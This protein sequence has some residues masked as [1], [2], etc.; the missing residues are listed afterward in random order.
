MKSCNLF[1]IINEILSQLEQK[2]LS[3]RTCE[4]Q[5]CMEANFF[6]I[7][8]PCCN[9]LIC[10]K[11]IISNTIM[12][13]KHQKCIIC[14]NTYICRNVQE[15][16]KTFRSIYLGFAEQAP[17]CISK[18]IKEEMENA[19]FKIKKSK[20]NGNIKYAQFSVLTKKMVVSSFK[21]II[22]KTKPSI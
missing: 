3:R 9:T 5:N 19:L 17:F 20:K 7:K 12:A 14:E 22:D 2:T 11:C 13:T 18:E 21:Y 1:L 16:E 4:N 6:L 8:V 10:I 15:F